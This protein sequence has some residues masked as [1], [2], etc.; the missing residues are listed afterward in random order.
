MIIDFLQQFQQAN[1]G[2]R[3]GRIWATKNIDPNINPGK[4]NISKVLG[5]CFSQA[6]DADFTGVMGGF[7]IL[8]DKYYAIGTDRVW[9]TSGEEPGEGWAEVPSTP[10]DC[11]S[12]SDIK[13]FNGKVYIATNAALTAALKSYDT[14]S[15][16]S[17]IDTLTNGKTKIMTVYNNRLYIKDTDETVISM[18]TAE[19]LATSSSYTID[20]N[21]TTGENQLITKIEAVSDGIWIAT[22]YT[23]KTGGEMI[24]WDGVTANVASARYKVPRGVLSI[25]V[26]DDRPYIIDSQ[27]RLRVFDGTT[28]TEIDRL[29]I[30]D[31]E[32]L[33]FA[34]QNNTRFVHP[35][36][37]SVVNDEL[38]ILVSNARD[39]SG[40]DPVERMPGG[41]WAYN[42]EFGLYHKYSFVNSDITA[43][44]PTIT[45]FGQNEIY[46]VGALFP[47][48]AVGFG[49]ALDDS[50]EVLASISFTTNASSFVDNDLAAV[51]ITN[52]ANDIK[53]A[54]YFVTAQLTA[55]TFDE[56]WKEVIAV[57]DRLKNSTDRIIIKY[58]TYETD[59]I[60]GTGTWA[61]DKRITSTADV[62]SL[63]A[64]DE[65]EILRG[66][67]AGECLT[68]DSISS[69]Q[70]RFKENYLSGMTGT[71]RFRGQKWKEIGQQLNQDEHFLRRILD[72]R[73]G[74]WVQFKVFMIGTG[75]SP[76]LIKLLSISSPN[77]NTK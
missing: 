64:G 17:T 55:E 43:A 50:S 69:T 22:I 68:I 35:N 32:L 67:G 44:T 10:T 66:T 2:D 53:K 56:T 70:I 18:S 7:T 20:I 48:S 1:R 31:E 23:N 24:F 75:K 11:S 72:A 74:A 12:N 49:V 65:I 58:R 25:A 37:M 61:E 30:V 39:E 46:K 63:S 13:A 59:P 4:V 41:I 57:H 6:D 42:S 52:Q 15:G 28:F 27:G 16:W 62:S 38:Y 45:D 5:K 36:G 47:A 34:D 26:K 19:A 40:K 9:R 51:A 71:C 21:A 29:P 60:Y 8:D 76:Q 3:L 14:S 33:D 54:G 77:A 73:H